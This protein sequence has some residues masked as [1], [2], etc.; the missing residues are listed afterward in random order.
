MWRNIQCLTSLNI[1]L[2]FKLINGFSRKIVREFSGIFWKVWQCKFSETAFLAKSAG[3]GVRH[4][5]RNAKTDPMVKISSKSDKW[6]RKIWI[7][8]KIRKSGN[9]RTIICEKP[10]VTWNH[11]YL[12]MGRSKWRSNWRS[13][14]RSKWLRQFYHLLTLG[15]LRPRLIRL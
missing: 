2:K 3:N 7:S 5:A 10:L 12:E 8:V 14:W 6:R 1:N 11:G 9:F 15:R 4:L 13:K